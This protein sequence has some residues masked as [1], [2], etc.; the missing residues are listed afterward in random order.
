MKYIIKYTQVRSFSQKEWSLFTAFFKYLTQNSR[1]SPDHRLNIICGRDGEDHPLISSQ[2]I[3]NGNKSLDKMGEAILFQRDRSFNNIDAVG[4]YY[5]F[6]TED[7]PYGLTA[8]T[9]LVLS[10]IFNNV[11]CSINSTGS[12]GSQKGEKNDWYNAY[13]LAEKAL[14]HFFEPNSKLI[15]EIESLKEHS[16]SYYDIFFKS[17]TLHAHSCLEKPVTFNMHCDVEL[18]P[19]QGKLLLREIGEKK[20]RILISGLNIDNSDLENKKEIYIG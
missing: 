5:S 19:D 18:F 10:R 8:K 14:R 4:D 17:Q 3:F 6:N 15:Q 12:L 11:Y 1:P 7:K 16:Y 2:I 9:M 13:L 20:R